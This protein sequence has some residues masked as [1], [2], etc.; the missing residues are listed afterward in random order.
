MDYGWITASGELTD[1]AAQ[2]LVIIILAVYGVALIWMLA[3]YI[4]RS[5]SLF[6]IAKRRGLANYGLAW[7]PV[8]YL[9]TVGSIA[10]GYDSTH[11]VSRKWRHVLLWLTL[12]GSILVMVLYVSLLVG[13]FSVAFASAQSQLNS[14]NSS[15][16]PAQLFYAIL[17]FY[18]GLIPL[19]ML[20]AARNVCNWICYYKLF[21]SCN[22]KKSVLLLLLSLLV[23]FAFPFCLLS[24]CKK[25]LGMPEAACAAPEPACAAPEPACAAV[26]PACAAAPELEAPA[27]AEQPAQE[28]AG[29][30]EI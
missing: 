22:P 4:I 29:P 11:G 13:I 30:E 27:A 28:S 23:P 6:H 24:C 9:W 1:G 7:V 18:V 17:G 26:E 14:W 5:L 20:Y 25:D 16:P 12:A 10:D 19:S 15:Q 21:E 8:G 2:A 3:N